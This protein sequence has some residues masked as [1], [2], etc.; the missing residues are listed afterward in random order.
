MSGINMRIRKTQRINGDKA[1][2]AKVFF[3]NLRCMKCIA[4][5]AAFHTARTTSAATS[6]ILGRCNYTIDTS[7]IVSTRRI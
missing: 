3:S 4:T 7:T 6:R 1:T 2:N 5:N